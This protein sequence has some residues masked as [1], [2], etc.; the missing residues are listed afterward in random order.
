MEV[1]NNHDKSVY[2]LFLFVCL[3][4]LFVGVF[5]CLLVGVFVCLFGLVWFDWFLTI[6]GVKADV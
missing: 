5:I 2:R 6:P 1:G 3:Y 4:C